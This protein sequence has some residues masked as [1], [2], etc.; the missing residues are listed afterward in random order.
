MR[1]DARQRIHADYC[2]PFLNKY[3]ALAVM[4]SYSRW[5]EVFLTTSP[6]SEF[7]Q[8]ALR[9]LFSREGV[10]IVLVTDNGSH[11][12]AKPLK[13]WLKGLGCRHLFTAP[14]HPQ[15]NGLAENFVRTLKSAI[16]SI[17]PVTFHDLDRG[18]DNFLMQYKNAAHSITGKSPA[19]LFKSRSLRTNL[20]CIGTA[21]VTFFKCNDLRPSTGVVIGRNGNRMVT[22]L[23]R[24]GL[25]SHRR[26]VDQVEFNARDASDEHETNTEPENP[27]LRRSERL[28]FQPIRDYKHPHAH[29]TCG[30][31]G[32]HLLYSVHSV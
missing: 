27:T 8:Y 30:G 20:E 28:R 14:R 15:S 25:S 12:T 6:N 19:E 3:Y 2:G 13:Y 26:H 16:N 1:Q 21:D 11:F 29:S 10:P 4:D 9:K 18:I 7:T 22:V 23:N 24:E 31:C 17:S 5:T 32:E